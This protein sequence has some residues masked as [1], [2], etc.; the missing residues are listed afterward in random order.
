MGAG[1]AGSYADKGAVAVTHEGLRTE[2]TT[3]GFRLQVDEPASVGGTEA[4]PTPY[5]HLATALAA[6][7]SMTLRMYADRKDLPLDSARTTVTFDRVHADD[8]AHCDTEEGRIEL[9]TRTVEL[10]G[11]LDDETRARLLEIADRCPVH[12]T[13]EGTIEVHTEGG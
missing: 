11:D 5:D 4:G 2:V 1:S 8:C 9:F 7:T 3:R 6:C 10:T 12:R 13:L